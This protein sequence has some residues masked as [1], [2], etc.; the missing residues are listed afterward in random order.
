M[1]N[2]VFR[3]PVRFAL[4]FVVTIAILGNFPGAVAA[5]TIQK[6][7]ISEYGAPF[8]IYPPQLW[9]SGQ[10]VDPPQLHVQG[11]KIVDSS[12][13]E[14]ILRGVNLENREWAWSDGNKSIDYERRAIP[15]LADSWNANVIK[16]AFASGPVLREDSAYLEQL[17][18]II[19]LASA[20]DMYV[21]LAYRYAEPDTSQARMPGDDAQEAFTF[22]ANRYRSEP[23]VLYGLQVEPHRC[24]EEDDE[25]NR[26]C[27]A[28][29]QEEFWNDLLVPRFTSMIDAIRE[30]HPNALIFVPGTH[31]G[32]FVHW[33]LENPVP[34]PNLVYKSHVYNSW[35]DVREK[36][37]FDE[38]HERY[39]LFIGEFGTTNTEESAM[40]L[41][42]VRDLLDYAQEKRIGWAAWLFNDAGKP[43]LLADKN[44]FEPNE[45]GQEVRSRLMTDRILAL[46]GDNFVMASS[47]LLSR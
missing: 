20:Y 18:E 30:Q 25:G 27:L 8:A 19:E 22:L 23:A 45:Y 42:D 15:E 47:N 35:E 6:E 9:L 12:G 17:D 43:T 1:T 14:V 31:Y 38:M 4:F 16:I 37:F 21:L 29:S 11:N 5:T 2:L 7:N 10:V 33:A 32:R 34:R 41:E 13:E 26:D 39:P 44:T 24:L 46:L 36:F 40:D 3:K 28:S